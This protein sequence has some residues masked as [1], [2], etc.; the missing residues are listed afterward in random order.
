MLLRRSLSASRPRPS[1]HTPLTALRS[2]LGAGRLS[3]KKRAQYHADWRRM[4]R[5]AERAKTA[6]AERLIGLREKQYN[7]PLSEQDKHRQNQYNI[8]G[9]SSTRGPQV[10]S[11][12][13]AG[14]APTKGVGPRVGGTESTPPHVQQQIPQAAKGK[15]GAVAATA[16]IPP[17]KKRSAISGL[18]S[19]DQAVFASELAKDTGL[20]PKVAAAWVKAEGGNQSGD[21]NWLNVGH[22]DSGPNAGAMKPVWNDPVSAA[23]ETAAVING[24]RAGTGAGILNIKAS[25]GNPT[26]R[27]FRQS[28]IPAGRRAAITRI[29]SIRPTA[30]FR[31]GPVERCRHG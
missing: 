15:P 9:V 30:R 31:R 29:C 26:R 20:S 2:D 10:G 3:P 16:A 24:K 6:R 1:R 22:T 17:S 21:Q 18:D 23:R 7:I 25:A 5:E 4:R 19:P 11:L 13:P 28:S 12:P 8:W 27:S 14:V